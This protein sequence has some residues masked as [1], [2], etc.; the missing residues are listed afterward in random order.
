MDFVFAFLS[1]C[2]FCAPCGRLAPVATPRP[3]AWTTEPTEAAELDNNAT[4]KTTSTTKT[5][6]TRTTTTTTTTTTTRTRR[7]PQETKSGNKKSIQFSFCGCASLDTNSSEFRSQASK[8]LLFSVTMDMDLRRKLPN[9]F[10]TNRCTGGEISIDN[11]TLLRRTL[12]IRRLLLLRQLLPKKLC[13]RPA[14]SLC[15]SEKHST[16][17]GPFCL[18]EEPPSLGASRKVFLAP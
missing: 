14:C 8:R 7:K 9:N 5:T 4:T 11:T 18:T 13:L 15:A 10:R 1:I 3:P 17:A 6:T 12:L 16:R 2:A